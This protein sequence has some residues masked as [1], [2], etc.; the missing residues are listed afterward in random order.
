MV[1]VFYALKGESNITSHKEC[2]LPSNP[3]NLWKPNV[4]KKFTSIDINKSLGK[5]WCVKMWWSCTPV[6]FEVKTC[7][8]LSVFI[9]TRKLLYPLKKKVRNQRNVT[10]KQYIPVFFQKHFWSAITKQNYHRNP[11]THLPLSTD[12]PEVLLKNN[13]WSTKGPANPCEARN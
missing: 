13:M 7:N 4:E 6:T 5:C 10:F 8:D 3:L 1:V 12:I 11:N 9:L 2:T